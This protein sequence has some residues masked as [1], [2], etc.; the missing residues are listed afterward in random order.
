MRTVFPGEL[1]ELPSHRD[2]D[3]T[4]ELYPG[5]SPISMNPHRMEP[6]EL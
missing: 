5:T 6:A 4:I 3:F 2:V 1:L